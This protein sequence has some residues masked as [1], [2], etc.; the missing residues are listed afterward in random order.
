MLDVVDRELNYTEWNAAHFLLK[1][2]VKV[3]ISKYQDKKK[4]AEEA[5][6]DI[7]CFLNC[8]DL[9]ADVIF[10]NHVLVE[11]EAHY[12]CRDL[13]ISTTTDLLLYNACKC[14]VEVKVW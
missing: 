1:S 2:R 4:K 10:V 6:D 3:A 8:Q 13:R 12:A 9:V 14:S 5:E 7:V 11:N